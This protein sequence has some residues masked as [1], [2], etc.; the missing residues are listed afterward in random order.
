MHEFST[1]VNFFGGPTRM[2]ALFGVRP[3]SVWLWEQQGFPGQR[4]FQVEVLSHGKFRHD[5]VPIRVVKANA[6]GPLSRG[7]PNNKAASGLNC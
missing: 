5:R 2:A 6:K 3:Q 7:T 4:P 1:I